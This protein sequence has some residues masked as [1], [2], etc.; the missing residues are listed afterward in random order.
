MRPNS[1]SFAMTS[2]ALTPMLLA[3]LATVMASSSLTFRLAAL[4]MVI[5]V[6]FMS[7]ATARARAA[8]RPFIIRPGPRR[9]A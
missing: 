6:C 5:S 1:M 8:L 4:G 9:L 3:R 2:L 7:F